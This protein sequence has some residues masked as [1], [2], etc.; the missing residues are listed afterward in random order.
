MGYSP[1]MFQDIL[2]LGLPPE[3]ESLIWVL[4]THPSVTQCN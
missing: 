4:R 3:A 1:E 2:A